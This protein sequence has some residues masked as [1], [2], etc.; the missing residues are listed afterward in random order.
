MTTNGQLREFLVSRR[1]RLRPP[2]VGLPD[3]DGARRVPGLRREEVAGLAKL[4]V[5]YYSRLEQGR[6]LNTSVAVINSIARALRLT[7]TERDHLELLVRAC[8]GVRVAAHPEQT[9]LRQD[10]ARLVDSLDHVPVWVT[11]LHMTVL[12]SNHL[13]RELLTD[14]PAREDLRRNFA[15]FVFLDPLARQRLVDWQPLAKAF[16][17]ALRRRR[18]RYPDDAELEDLVADLHADGKFAQWWTQYDIQCTQLVDQR[19]RHPV[20]G[21]IVVSWETLYPADETG[22]SITIG[23]VTPGSPHARALRDLATS[24]SRSRC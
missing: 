21:E 8:G 14:F 1:A 24:L 9:Q 3:S 22:Q 18:G 10:L 6:P 16:V 23:S 13:C 11:D 15:R 2:D 19:I 20:A 4:S 7:A 17:A 5:D 12:A